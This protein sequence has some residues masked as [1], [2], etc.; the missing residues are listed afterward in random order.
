MHLPNATK[1]RPIEETQLLFDSLVTVSLPSDSII[2]SFSET[3]EVYH[4]YS[5]F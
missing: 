2:T 4:Y 5:L 1:I 3:T